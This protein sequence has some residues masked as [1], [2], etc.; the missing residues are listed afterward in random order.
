MDSYLLDTNIII[1]LLSG[2]PE[3]HHNI[4]K[5]FLSEAEENNHRFAV[6]PLVIAEV[7]FVLTGKVYGLK[8]E[9]VVQELKSFLTNPKITVVNE[10]E[11]E[12][13]LD[14]FLASKLDF[15]DCYLLAR[16][17]RIE[18]I[19]LTTFDKAIA[20]LQPEKVKLLEA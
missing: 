2:E 17:S 11:I 6:E 19:Q 20:R 15:V 8:R 1:R 4:V 12:I 18:D 3:D 14:Y 13:A 9:L 16:T 5:R 10:Q 7:V